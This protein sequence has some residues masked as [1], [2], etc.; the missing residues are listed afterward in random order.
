MAPL[1]K[2][3]T[4]ALNKQKPLPFS[5]YSSVREQHILNVP[6][7]KPLLIFILNEEK[8]LGGPTAH[9]CRAREFIFLSNKTSVD[10]RNI[11][12]Q[13]YY[14]L[15]IEFDVSDFSHLAAKN[16]TDDSYCIGQTTY[17]LERV[18]IQFIE[19]SCLAPATLWHSR[20]RELLDFLYHLGHHA[21][22]NLATQHTLSH[23]I[24]SM[25]MGNLKDD[26]HIEVLCKTLAMSESTLLRRLKTEGTGLQDIK[27][28]ARLS[29]GLHL[30][31]ST[32]KPIGYIAEACGYQSQSRFT[33]RFKQRFGLTPREL[34]KTR[35]ND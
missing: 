9:C 4:Q 18:L 27:D 23:Q 16:N 21:V 34:R 25:I 33:E 5:V 3:I 11:P 17:E 6:I 19:W 12:E 8:H 7:V 35:L 2:T 31:Q 32:L 20:K 13:E 30:L 14:A 26:W 28:Q 22:A 29:Y 24:H 10:M 1:R 15:L